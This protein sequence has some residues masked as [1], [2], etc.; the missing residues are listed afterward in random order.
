MAL[1]TNLSGLPAKGLVSERIG[2]QGSGCQ[3]EMTEPRE[4]G[5]NP[6]PFDFLAIPLFFWENLLH[7]K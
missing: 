4:S 6:K 5:R 3:G 1:T 2:T 7:G